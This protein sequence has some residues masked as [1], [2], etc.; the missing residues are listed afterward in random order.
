MQEGRRGGAELRCRYYGD[1]GME[2]I[3][4]KCIAILYH[5]I[6]SISSDFRRGDGPRWEGSASLE[7]G[8]RR[9]AR[10]ARGDQSR[11]LPIDAIM[12]W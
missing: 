2:I 4:F 6:Q 9:R 12:P 1:L 7:A 11:D 10:V 8:G 5:V 3:Y